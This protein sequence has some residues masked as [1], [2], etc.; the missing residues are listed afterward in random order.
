MKKLQ[1]FLTLVFALFMQFIFAQEKTVTGVVSDGSG[2]TIPG[3][4]ITVKG[5]KRSTQTDFEGVFKIQAKEGEMLVFSF[6]GMNTL[7]R[8]ATSSKMIVQLSDESLKLTEV[9]INNFGV[10]VKKNLRASSVAKVKGDILTSSGEKSFLNSL[11]SKASNVSVVSNSGDPGAGSYLQIRGQNTITGSNQPL[12]VIDGIPISSDERGSDVAGVSQQSRTND[13]NPNDIENITILKGASASALWGYRA[14]N[15]VILI[16][17]KRGKKGKITVELNSAYSYD[18][19]NLRFKTQNVFGQGTNGNF[20]KNNPNSYGNIIAN[21]AGGSDIFNTAGSYFVSDTGKKYYTIAAGGKRSKDNFNDSNYEGVIGS[22]FSLDNHVSISGGDTNGSFYAS[23]GHLKQDGIIQGSDYERTSLDFNSSYKIND[24]TTFKGKFQFTG[25][26]SQRIQQGSNT[27]GLLLGL[28]RTP[29]DFDN[30]DYKGTYYNAAGLPY[31]NSHRAY[32]QDIGTFDYENGASD[33]ATGYNNPLWTTK[34]QKNPNT[35]NRYIAGLQIQHDINKNIS[36]LGRFG[37]DGYSDKRLT[38]YP[39]SS[40]ENNGNGSAS[41]SVTDF[42][43]YNVDLM[44]LGDIKLNENLGLNYTVGTNIAATEIASRGGSYIN[45]LTDSD[46][47]SYDNAIIAD[48]TTFLNRTN[49]RLSGAYFSGAFDYKSYLFATLGGRYETSSTFSPNLKAYFYPTVE[50]GYLVSKNLNVKEINTAKLRATYGQVAIIPQEYLGTTYFPGATGAEG[51]GPAYDAGAYAGS[52]QRSGLGGNPNLKPEIKTEFE[53]GGDFE[54]FNR[55][56][57][58]IT[59]YTNTIKDNLVAVPLNGSSSFSS[60][61][62]NFADIENKGLELDFNIAILKNTPLKVSVYGTWGQNRNKVTRLENTTSLLLNGFT[63]SSSRAVLGQPLGVLWGG[64]WERDANNNY[65]LDSNGFPT[66]APTDGVLGDPNPKWRGGAGLRLEYKGFA[67]NTLFDASIGGQLWDGT[68]GALNNFGT[69]VVSGNITTLSAAQAA[70]IV[71]FAGATAASLGTVN[72][73]GSV[74]VRGNIQDFGGGPVLLN[75]AWY[76]GNG[77][78]FGP[79][80]EQFIKSATWVKFRELGLSYSLNSKYLNHT[81][82]SAITLSLTARNLWLWTEDKT[83]GQDP[84]SNLTGG[85][86][87]R[88]LQYFNHPNTKSYLGSI[89]IKF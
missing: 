77:G 69:S 63:G 82:V 54:F 75:Q 60:L 25:S 30:T 15:G 18:E 37:L 6:V 66:V 46:K 39:K 50:L 35:V 88:G 19:V 57:F 26:N 2:V 34:V 53:L 40:R 76:Q 27:S 14:A 23:F 33:L 81:G 64:R 7:E 85:S 36:I 47:F 71:N 17:T 3:A 5:T 28:Y 31:N 89:N 11:S 42:Q 4:N 12:Y 38:M 22:G 58:N 73:D 32:R 83:I 61:Y 65:V 45:F 72:P 87:G 44:I 20:V 24:K 70:S 80:A 78:G 13:I 68:N 49:S 21:R 1:F 29:S 8:P 9:I 55:L 84:E 79:V 74:S 86:A 67:L 48:K 62:G 10:E 16:T 56:K 51:Y 43:Q 41:E 52:F 59:Y